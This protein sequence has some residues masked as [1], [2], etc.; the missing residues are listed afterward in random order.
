MHVSE[1][2]ARGLM[3]IAYNPASLLFEADVTAVDLGEMT[4]RAW[5]GTC[6]GP[7]W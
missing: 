7:P 4:E 1:G 2:L 6:P 5:I 3:G